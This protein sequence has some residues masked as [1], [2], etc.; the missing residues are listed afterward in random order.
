MIVG[1]N[2]CRRDVDHAQARLAEQQE[3][4]EEALLVGLHQAPTAV[5]QAIECHRGDD[6][7]RL[8]LDVQSHRVP[9]ASAMLRWRRSKCGVPLVVA[10][11]GQVDWSVADDAA[12]PTAL[13]T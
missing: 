1:C 13:T 6:H 9:H 11:L 7:H 12:A 5:A 3:Q 8:V 4:E 10:E 2:R